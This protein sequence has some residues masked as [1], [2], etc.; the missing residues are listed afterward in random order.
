MPGDGTKLARIKNNTPPARL[1]DITRLI[2]RAGR[3]PTGVDRVELAYLQRLITEDLPFF[4]LARTSLGYV[5]LDRKGASQIEARITQKIPWGTADLFRLF[6]TKKTA[7]VLRAESDLRR[8][9]LSRCV[10]GRLGQ[11]LAKHL[12]AGTA[13]LNVGHSNITERVLEALRAHVGGKVSIFVHDTIPLDFP[14]YQRPETPERFRALL[15]RAATYADVFICNSQATV[16]QVKAHSQEAHTQAEFVVAHL[17]V[18]PAGPDARELPSDLDLAK[19]YFVSV[20][21][22]EPRKRYDFLLDLWDSLPTHLQVPLYFCGARGWNN[23]K[24]FDRLDN[25]PAGSRIT[26]LNNLSDAAVSALVQSATALL[27][28]SDAEG[29]GLP[30]VEA[31]TLGTTV[32]C[33]KLPVFEEILG[34]IPVYAS[35]SNRY[36]WTDIIERLIHEQSKGAKAINEQVY[37]PP[38]WDNHF[39]IVLQLT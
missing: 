12:P 29:F 9:C 7:D 13:Y 24:V 15:R 10:S 37:K 16:D 5:L 2:S 26:E 28:P 18:L 19:P 14:Q 23:N 34:D 1:L 33:Q 4:A 27:F 20:G 21:T 11:M 36:L 3:T 30:P 39:D 6:S 38:S 31:A 17:G 25:L 32:V 35:T 22:I 8:V